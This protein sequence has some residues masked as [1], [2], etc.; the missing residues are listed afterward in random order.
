MLHLNEWIKFCVCGSHIK[1]CVGQ[2]VIDSFLKYNWGDFG[3]EYLDRK[4]SNKTHFYCTVDMLGQGFDLKRLKGRYN[5][6]LERMITLALCMKFLCSC[7]LHPSLSLL[8]LTVLVIHLQG[9][10]ERV[11]A[12]NSLSSL[13]SRWSLTSAPVRTP[14]LLLLFVT[15]AVLRK[16]PYFGRTV[17]RFSGPSHYR[18]AKLVS[19]RH[20]GAPENKPL[21]Y[22]CL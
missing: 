4:L 17:K 20:W 13:S 7:F 9:E 1:A 10:M 16:R 11:A 18:Q 12:G 2:N 3:F 22:D 8:S 21:I 19:G 15:H 6:N 14:L 5:F